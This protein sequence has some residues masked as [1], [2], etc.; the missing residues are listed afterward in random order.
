MK[1]QELIEELVKRGYDYKDI[2]VLTQT[3]E[4][5]VNATTWLNEKD[6]LFI[7][8]C[9]DVRRRRPL[10]DRSAHELPDA[11]T[12]DL[13]AGLLSWGC[14]YQNGVKGPRD[15]YREAEGSA[16]RSETLPL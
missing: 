10:G 1:I 4:D 3:N 2:A 7:S 12:D 13:S 6:V 15:R 9:L 14:L 5:A 8:L 16:S 11:P